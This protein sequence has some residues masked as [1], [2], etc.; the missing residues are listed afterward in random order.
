LIVDL[1]NFG[2]VRG[3]TLRQGQARGEMVMAIEEEL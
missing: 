2:D 1:T 3:V